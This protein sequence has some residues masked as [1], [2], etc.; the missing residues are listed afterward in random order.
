MFQIASIY[1][2]TLL[3]GLILAAIL[4]SMLPGL[5]AQEPPTLKELKASGARQS[6]YRTQ[7]APAAAPEALKLSP[8]R[9]KKELMP[10]PVSYTHQT[11]PTTPYV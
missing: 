6:R 9:L 4:A 11:L 2:R 10:I 5:I 7:A 1:D 3:P 8:G